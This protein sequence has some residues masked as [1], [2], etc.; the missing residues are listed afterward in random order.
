[1]SLNHYQMNS[2]PLKGRDP[3]SIA[4]TTFNNLH[5]FWENHAKMGRG[6]WNEY[7]PK[8]KWKTWTPHQPLP[9]YFLE[10]NMIS[11]RRRKKHASIV[12]LLSNM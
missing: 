10:I 5:Y 9:N 2:Y 12:N 11:W 1:M 6:D 8:G 7:A 3:N 4:R